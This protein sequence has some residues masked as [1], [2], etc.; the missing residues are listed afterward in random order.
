ME[1]WKLDIQERIIMNIDKIKS[2]ILE[3]EGCKLKIKVNIGRGK[4][5]YLEGKIKEIYD[6]LFLIET[7][8][9]IKTFTYSD[10][11]TKQLVISKFD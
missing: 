2:K 3:L 8:R 9:G 6:H 10:I 5:E 7:N 4:Y 1:K 11:V